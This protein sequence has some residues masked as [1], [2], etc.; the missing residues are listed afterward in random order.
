MSH[1]FRSL[2][3]VAAKTSHKKKVIFFLSYFLAYYTEQ[4]VLSAQV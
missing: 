4:R 1:F 3:P 2:Y